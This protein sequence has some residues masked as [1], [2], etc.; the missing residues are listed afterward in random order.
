MV[1]TM[2]NR[3]RIADFIVRFPGRD[4]DEI[5]KALKITPRQ[6]VNQVCRALANAGVVE[7]RPNAA[8]K[9]ANYP[10]GIEISPLRPPQAKEQRHP[11]GAVDATAD[12]FWEGNVTTTV[13]KYLR[14]E[15]W[16]IISQADTSTKER[17]VDIHATRLGVELM[18]EVKGY[19]S[20]GYRD[21]NR[22]GETK[23]TNPSVQAQHW[24]AHALLKALRMQSAN[25]EAQIAVALPDF[26]RY[27]SLF[28]ETA[29]ALNRLGIIT[30]FLAE[31]GQV[32][33]IG[34]WAF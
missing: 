13:A 3:T 32:E 23:P 33:A 9:L 28:E 20:R 30:L 24:Y 11:K 15:D 1:I 4:D 18:I 12:W 25:P 27:R 31:T 6:T 7:R 22:S 10:L 34:L 17:G 5:S 2:D 19:P 8:G 16:A 29:S 26:P 21:P 14:E